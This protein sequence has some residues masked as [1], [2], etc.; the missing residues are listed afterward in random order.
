LV[1]R[2]TISE[3][4]CAILTTL[5][6]AN[7]KNTNSWHARK[8]NLQHAFPLDVAM[9]PSAKFSFIANDNNT[10]SVRLAPGSTIYFG[11]LKFIVDR[12]GRLSLSPRE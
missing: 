1:V 6:L 7:A 10:T 3:Q 4:E 8:R 12:L 9:V 2:K 5:Y 11:S